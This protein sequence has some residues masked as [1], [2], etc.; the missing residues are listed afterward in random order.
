MM[1]KLRRSSS[2]L[3]FFSILF[4]AGILF[5]SV[6]QLC[7]EDSGI[8]GGAQGST[9]IV[10]G[11]DEECKEPSA[12]T[13]ECIVHK[14][15]YDTTS[16]NTA[17]SAAGRIAPSGGEK[18]C[19]M[20]SISYSLSKTGENTAGKKTTT[21]SACKICGASYPGTNP[22]TSDHDVTFPSNPKW[23]ALDCGANPAS[24]SGETAS[25]VG[26]DPSSAVNSSSVVFK[27]D[28]GRCNTYCG[29]LPIGPYTTNFTVIEVLMLFAETDTDIAVSW[30]GYTE[31]LLVPYEKNLTVAISAL[32]DPS[33]ADGGNV[34]PEGKPAWTPDG[35]GDSFDFPVPAPGEYTVTAE[36]GNEVSVI[37]RAIKVKFRPSSK[38]LEWKAADTHDISQ[39]LTND[40]FD[41]NKLGWEILEGDEFASVDADGLVTFTM[42][43]GNS[44]TIKVKAYS[45]ELPDDCSDIFTIKGE[46][47]VSV[48]IK[49]LGLSEEIQGTPNETSPGAFIPIDDFP[50]T[51]DDNLL[52]ASLKI[53]PK[54]SSGTAKL[55]HPPYVGV[56]LDGEGKQPIPGQ[57][58][59]ASEMPST[60]YVKERSTGVGGYLTLSYT[61]EDGASFSDKVKVTVFR[62]N[63][64]VQNLP[65]EQASPDRNEADPGAKVMLNNDDDNGNS[66]EDRKEKGEIANEDDLVEEKIVFEPNIKNELN[67]GSLEFYNGSGFDLTGELKV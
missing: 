66:I 63:L 57:W 5:L 67:V 23:D 20:Q 31:T 60:V 38:N 17:C 27:F 33:G 43:S 56:Y 49:F 42:E 3:I 48:D 12:S 37:I 58:N 25:F 41:R 52:A 26:N 45:T 6:R 62:V 40:T 53:T 1:S 16:T 32:S 51:G 35:E 21:Y 36:C 13:E 29:T 65:E 24:G 15:E 44:K 61:D 9:S 34:W 22:E 8:S 14:H 46:K 11:T 55:S 47:N 10:T 7:G 4:S 28:D 19:V 39:Y 30:E 2:L 59:P 64:V 50:D 54:A 18:Y